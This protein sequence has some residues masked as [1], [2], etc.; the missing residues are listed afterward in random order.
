MSKL[1]RLD[2]TRA[3]KEIG[4]LSL[5]AALTWSTLFIVAFLSFLSCNSGTLETSSGAKTLIL[6]SISKVSSEE[7]YRTVKD[8]EAFGT[9]FTWEKQ[10]EVAEYLRRRLEE[11]GIEVLLDE[12]SFND[13]KWKNVV[14]TIKGKGRPADITMIIA[15][16]DSISKQPESIAPGADDNGSGTAALLEIA[17]VLS[18]VRL[19][20]TVEFVIFSNEEQGHLGS[21]HFAKKAKS[22]GLNLKGVVNLDIIGYNNPP[23]SKPQDKV[24]LIESTKSVMRAAR[25][26]I[27]KILYPNGRVTIA[28]RGE[29]RRLVQ[30]TSAVMKKYTKL[31]V[32]A[33]VDEDCG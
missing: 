26:R 24:D 30:V 21:K 2:G 6:S 16:F 3:A 11:Y 29:N 7:L 32:N 5:K 17:R 8:L 27:F 23:I 10:D 1:I 12:Y 4:P 31:G 13:R 33:L 28:G 9:R 25:S 18:N 19:R 20:D 14:G 15:H 22:E